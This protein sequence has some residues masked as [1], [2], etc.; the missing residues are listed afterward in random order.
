MI[1]KIKLTKENIKPKFTTI[2]NNQ[3][4]NTNNYNKEAIETEEID[5]FKI[6]NN[7]TQNEVANYIKINLESNRKNSNKFNRELYQRLK[8]QLSQLTQEERGFHHER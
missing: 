1:D 5:L 2:N 7:Q 4:I 3:N 6:S 8:E